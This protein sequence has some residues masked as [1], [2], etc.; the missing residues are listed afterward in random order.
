VEVWP[1][2]FHVFQIAYQV[3]PEARAALDRV[4]QFVAAADA[5]VTATSQIANA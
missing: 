2:L 5:S 4:E 1:G 3:L